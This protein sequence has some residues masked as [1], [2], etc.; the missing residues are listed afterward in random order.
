M[1]K[2][3]KGCGRWI[4]FCPKR[5]SG[6]RIF[7]NHS[8]GQS[9][10]TCRPRR[11]LARGRM[12]FLGWFW[13]FPGPLQTRSN[14]RPYICIM[15]TIKVMDYAQPQRKFS[16]LQTRCNGRLYIC[17]EKWT[18]SRG[19]RNWRFQM[20]DFFNPRSSLERED[21]FLE[22]FWGTPLGPL[23]FSWASAAA[24]PLTVARHSIWDDPLHLLHG[25]GKIG[26]A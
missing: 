14:G 25:N 12:N 16:P 13:K 15:K 1:G 26:S 17:I 11:P 5:S 24:C 22:H 18:W 9:P 7:F 10:V 6:V 2:K 8:R 21:I 3:I 23:S 19:D 4:L 20:D